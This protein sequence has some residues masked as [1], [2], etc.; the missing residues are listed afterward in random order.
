MFLY[1][2][3]ADEKSLKIHLKLKPSKSRWQ[4]ISFKCPESQITWELKLSSVAIARAGAHITQ[5][6]HI[7]SQ[8]FAQTTP[9]L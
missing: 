5:V 2:W 3:L 4:K 6:I 1:L 8:V 7:I 9:P